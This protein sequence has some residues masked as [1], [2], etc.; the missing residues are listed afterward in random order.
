MKGSER[1]GGCTTIAV[2]WRG[3]T[4]CLLTSAYDLRKVPV[5]PATL[6]HHFSLA[7]SFLRSFRSP[8]DP[9]SEPL[10]R[11]SRPTFLFSDNSRCRGQAS[12]WRSV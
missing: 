12:G 3:G 10:L 8:T 6:A 9:R 2:G 4:S 1:L 7:P 5:A 11:L